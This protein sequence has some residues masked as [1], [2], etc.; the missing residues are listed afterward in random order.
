M[1]LKRDS[2]RDELTGLETYQ[3]FLKD[4]DDRIAKAEDEE[5]CVSLAMADVDWFMKLN[6]AHGEAIGD[7]VL[8]ALAAHLAGSV[9]DA[10]ATCATGAPASSGKGGT[11]YRIGGEEFALV[12]PGMAKEDAF[13][14][15][16]RTRSTF[17]AQNEHTF[18][19]GDAEATVHVTFSIGLATYPDDAS[20]AQDLVRKADEALYRAKQTGRNRITLAREE[21]MVTK[22]SYYTHGQLERLSR[23]AEREGVGEAVLL[24]E[25][26]D[27][28]IRKFLVREV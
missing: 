7:E 10:G 28:L 8:K 22:T 3:A 27:D 24:R 17:D 25:A 14:H 1:A 15:L 18:R 9:A 26:L 2:G 13:L 6:E 5:S 23:L 12:L 20:K 16:E 11:V 4:L 21:K 19:A